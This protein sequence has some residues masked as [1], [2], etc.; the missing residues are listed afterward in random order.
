MITIIP[1]APENVAAFNATGAVTK[2]D[3]ENLVFPRVKAKIEQ[4]GELNYLMYLD[5]DLDNFTAGAWLEDALLGLK[6][7]TK[8]NRA[9]ILTDN[10][11]V[12]NF[13]E[14]FSVLMPGE[15]KSFPKGNLY[16]ALYWCKN[17][18]EVEA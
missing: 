15:F 6:N 3:F 1:E 12:Q 4:F 18:N 11:H 9:A 5:T 13:T 7:L 2:E 14:I 17:G 10:Q 8:W 16:N